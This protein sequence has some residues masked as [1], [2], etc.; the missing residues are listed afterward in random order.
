MPGRLRKE[1][2]QRLTVTKSDTCA[3]MIAP[4]RRLRRLDDWSAGRLIDTA[5]TIAHEDRP[6]MPDVIF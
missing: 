2:L 1:Q 3:P 4:G 6:R 5:I